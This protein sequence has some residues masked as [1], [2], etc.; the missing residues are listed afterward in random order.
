MNPITDE[1]SDE[2]GDKQEEE[3]PEAEARSPLPVIPG[4][5]EK[6]RKL[7]EEA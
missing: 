6:E 7:A 1:G 5:V 4:D 3:D 2:D